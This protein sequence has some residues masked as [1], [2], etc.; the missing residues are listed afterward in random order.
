M[1][2]YNLLAHLFGV[3]SQSSDLLLENFHLFVILLFLIIVIRL[4]L[5]RWLEFFQF[6]Y[7][8]L[9]NL[10]FPENIWL[11]STGNLMVGIVGWRNEVL[12]YLLRVVS[13]LLITFPSF[14][15][16]FL[17]LC[18][19]RKEQIYFSKRL[20]VMNIFIRTYCPRRF[21]CFKMILLLE[22]VACILVLSFCIE[23]VCLY[24][25]IHS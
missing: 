21:N 9:G 3:K 23:K 6:L 11:V 2:L 1:H 19:F 5:R 20:I 14:Y 15:S 22:R 18:L 24:N 4:E 7:E 10:C 25:W 16:F 12:R 13:W 17:G 8:A